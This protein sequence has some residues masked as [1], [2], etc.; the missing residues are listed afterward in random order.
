MEKSKL[1]L[2]YLSLSRKALMLVV[3]LLV[4]SFLMLGPKLVNAQ[5]NNVKLKISP[6][7]F[8]FSI[9]KGESQ[10]S[11]V[12]IT[13]PN[14]VEI[15]VTTEKEEPDKEMDVIVLFIE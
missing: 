4:A 1:I 6:L 12:S 11:F 3:L 2:L 7:T 5:D 13:N 10:T 14:E 9:D 15:T 8:S